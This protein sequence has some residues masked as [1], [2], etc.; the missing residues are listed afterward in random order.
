MKIYNCT[1]VNHGW[2]GNHWFLDRYYLSDKTPNKIKEKFDRMSNNLISYYTRKVK[3]HK[4][5]DDLKLWDH[6]QKKKNFLISIC[7]VFEIEVIED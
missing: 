4:M 3:E 5:D 1:I 7:Q 6:Y 2:G